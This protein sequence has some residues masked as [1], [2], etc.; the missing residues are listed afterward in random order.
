MGDFV[1]AGELQVLM[2]IVHD[3]GPVIGGLLVE[4]AGEV[5]TSGGYP[6]LREP[7]FLR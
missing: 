2:Q 4:E 1:A 7:G 6:Q 3:Q 5:F